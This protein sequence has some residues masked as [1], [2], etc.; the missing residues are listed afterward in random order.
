M[1]CALDLKSTMY[2]ICVRIGGEFLSNWGCG[3]VEKGKPA[4]LG[5]P[6]RSFNRQNVPLSIGGS[7]GLL[8]KKNWAIFR[9]RLGLPGLSFSMCGD[10]VCMR[11]KKSLSVALIWIRESSE[12]AF[13][14]PFI[15]PSFCC[16]ALCKNW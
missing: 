1:V 9:V 14:W 10:R 7:F 8:L 5:A 2:L 13:S 6:S 12:I 4:S 16:I 15:A 3:G 11:S